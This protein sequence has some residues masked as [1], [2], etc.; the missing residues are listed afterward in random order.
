[1]LGLGLTAGIG[2]TMSIFISTLSFT[3]ETNINISKLAI[4][5]G[6][7]L[8][9]IIGIIVLRFARTSHPQNN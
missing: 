4:I 7:L 5:A 9:A 3:D 1:M 8:S 2:F 6:S